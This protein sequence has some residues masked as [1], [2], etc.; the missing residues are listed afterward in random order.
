MFSSIL[1]LIGDDEE[2]MLFIKCVFTKLTRNL[3]VDSFLHSLGR[4]R[5]ELTRLITVQAAKIKDPV[6]NAIYLSTTY[7]AILQTL[8]VSGAIACQFLI[9]I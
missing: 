3:L 9:M 7:E 2:P 4:L 5:Q 8:S 1:A 6:Q